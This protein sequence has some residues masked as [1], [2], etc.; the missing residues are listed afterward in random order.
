MQAA[1][2]RVEEEVVF[3]LIN[4]GRMGDKSPIPTIVVRGVVGFVGGVGG[5]E[6]GRRAGTFIGGVNAVSGCGGSAWR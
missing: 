4:N 1:T 3:Y 2:G 6:S 5:P